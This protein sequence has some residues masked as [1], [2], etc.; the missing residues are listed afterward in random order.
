MS[1]LIQ[2]ANF[3]LVN[4]TW[5]PPLWY[6]NQTNCQC[7]LTDNGYR[8][9]RPP[10]IT[11]NSSDTTTRTM[12]GG[13]LLQFPNPPLIQGH[14]YMITFDIRGKTTNQPTSTYWSNNAGWSGGSYGLG[15]DASDIKFTNIPANFN[16]NIW[17]P[18]I[19]EWTVNGPVY[20]TCTT[21]YSSFTQGQ[22]YPVFRDFK[23]GFDYVSTGSLGTDLYIK[24]IRMYD[25]TNKK[26]I[27]ISK[28]SI[29]SSEA[30]IEPLSNIQAQ[31]SISGEIKA[32]QFYEI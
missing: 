18:V 10:N 32:N 29:V 11:Y 2:Q 4:K 5:G 15:T 27:D 23:Y 16:S 31:F 17:T 1:N 22:T 8:I 30:I 28:K 26:N 12:W 25:L 21:S 3:Q 20:K 24:N 9:Y 6:Y 7:T 19:Y 13:F 14:R